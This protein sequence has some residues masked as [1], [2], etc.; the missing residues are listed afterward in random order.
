[1]V[2]FGKRLTFIAFALALLSILPMGL[3]SLLG[4]EDGNP[5]GLG[6]LMLV[7]FPL[8]SLLSLAGMLL[9]AAGEIRRR[10]QER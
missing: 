9:W 1:M 4:P 5:L 6:L 7:G 8:F 10:R 2:T 3:Y